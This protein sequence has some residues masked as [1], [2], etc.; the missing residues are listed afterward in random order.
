MKELEKIRAIFLSEDID[1][2]TRAD[3]E[4]KI[5][6]WESGLIKNE[7]FLSWQ[8]HDITKEILRQ[9]KQSYKEMAIQLAND[10]RI[11]N[12]TRQ[13][14]WSKQDACLFIINLADKDAKTALEGLEK[15]ISAA[16]GAI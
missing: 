1:E 15:E 4:E 5:R 3:N 14:L 7:N 10:R 11:S 2:E 6:E 16:L 8:Q 12:E 9:V 13:T